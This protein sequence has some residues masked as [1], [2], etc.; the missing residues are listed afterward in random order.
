MDKENSCLKD[1]E[2]KSGTGRGLTDV[3][4]KFKSSG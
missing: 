4:D 2:T 1:G 3:A